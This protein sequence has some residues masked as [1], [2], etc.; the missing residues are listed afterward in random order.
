[1]IAAQKNDPE[2]QQMRSSKFMK[3]VEVV[4][5]SRVVCNTSTQV[6]RPYVPLTLRRRAF[7]HYHGMNHPNAKATKR[8]LVDR[9]F[10]PSLT[11]DVND[12]CK[13]CIPC[14]ASKVT[15]H[16]QT[17][18]EQINPTGRRFEHVHIDLVGPLP[19]SNGHKYLLTMVDRFSRWPEAVPLPNI[20]AATVA[21]AFVNGWISRFGVPD[22]ITHDRGTQF[23]P[24][25]F[26]RLADIL[27]SSRIRTSAYN[28]RANGMVERF[29]HQMKGVLK[30][31]KADT[32]W[33]ELLP[34][35]LLGIR[36][37][38]KED[39]K[40]SSAEMVYGT[41]LTLPADLVDC[42]SAVPGSDSIDFVANLRRRMTAMRTAISRPASHP[43]QHIPPALATCDYVFVRTDSHRGPLQR[44]YTGPYKVLAHGRHTIKIET[45]GGPEDVAL[46]RLKPAHV[47][48]DYLSFDLPRPRGRPPIVPR[49]LGGVM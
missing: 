27:G 31:F 26:A 9:Y 36:S 25:L 22:T 5:G 42:S 30:C 12:W 48:Q 23:E 14:Q 11:N 16:V 8:L 49:P 43:V 28:P 18:P 34:L 19:P 3:T 47:D 32:N 40:A 6:N 4:P 46:H 38:I 15:T 17:A 29:H 37:T 13:T 41:T 24:Q 1:L 33:T 44:P 20:E 45:P 7:D 10:W 35:S 21:S 2:L 39:L